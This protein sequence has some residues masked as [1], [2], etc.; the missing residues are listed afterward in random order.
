MKFQ[1]ENRSSRIVVMLLIWILFVIS[2]FAKENSE[3]DHESSKQNTSTFQQQVNSFS[4]RVFM[5]GDA[6]KITTFPDTGSFLN[7]IYPIDDRGYIELPMLGK[8]Q[9]SHMGREDFRNYIRENF[10]D[11]LRFPEGL[12]V[13][14]LVR[15]SVLGG[16]PAPG[17]YYY[18][19]EQSLWGLI[20]ICGGTLS[21]D[22]LKEMHWKRDGKNVKKNLIPYL[23]KG[24]SLRNMGFRS[25]DQIWVKSPGKPGLIQKITQ[26]YLPIITF[27][28]TAITTYFTFQLLFEGRFTGRRRGF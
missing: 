27:T 11:Y 6:V 28:T 22:G 10:K 1:L 19:P 25:G 8:V 9:I 4:G 14:P 23:Q 13:K 26:N 20:Q 15:V 17:F 2:G 24:T 21:E 16:V 12:Q 5:P 18:D 3:T 7:N